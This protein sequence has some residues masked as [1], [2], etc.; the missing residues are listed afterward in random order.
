MAGWKMTGKKG[1]RKAYP[2]LQKHL[3]NE[4]NGQ[5]K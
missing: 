3:G 4:Y 2:T 1:K 5:K